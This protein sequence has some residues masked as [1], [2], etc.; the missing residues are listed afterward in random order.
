MQAFPYSFLAKSLEAASILSNEFNR[1]KVKKW[2]IVE[3]L[4]A[5][6][7][8]KNPYCL[9]S[10]WNCRFIVLLC[11][12]IVGLLYCYSKELEIPDAFKNWGEGRILW[13]CISFSVFC[14]VCRISDWYACLLKY[15]KT[16]KE[17]HTLT[18]CF[19]GAGKALLKTPHGS[20]AHHLL[21]ILRSFP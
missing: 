1:C 3:V 18:Y 15:Y 21:H 16:I 12:W 17:I 11:G 9:Q 4:M 10:V 20:N 14:F 5:S 8:S 13:I 7:A 2:R 6:S 19:Y